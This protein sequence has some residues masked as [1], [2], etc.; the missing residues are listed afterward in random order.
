MCEH[1]FIGACAECDGSGQQPEP[2]TEVGVAPTMPWE[3]AACANYVWRWTH[4][5]DC[6]K[7]IPGKPHENQR[8]A[9]ALGQEYLLCGPCQEPIDRKNETL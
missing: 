2:D 6:G 8:K 7:E 5:A 9:L 4:C 1:G 3:D